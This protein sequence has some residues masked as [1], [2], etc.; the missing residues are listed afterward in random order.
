MTDDFKEELCAYCELYWWNIGKKTP[1]FK[2]ELVDLLKEHRIKFS[3]R[4]TETE[5]IFTF[6]FKSSYG[7]SFQTT[8]TIQDF[9]HLA[10]LVIQ[11]ELVRMGDKSQL[12]VQGAW[13]PT[14]TV[15]A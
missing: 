3:K 13:R 1:S 10:K 14:V 9:R 12:Y 4:K 2:G 8:G 5:G 15:N 7:I 6:Y 11:M